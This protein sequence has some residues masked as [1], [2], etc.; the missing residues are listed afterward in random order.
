VHFVF[1]TTQK[2]A[3]IVVDCWLIFNIKIGG[4]AKLAQLLLYGS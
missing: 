4:F 3:L 2:T 1:F